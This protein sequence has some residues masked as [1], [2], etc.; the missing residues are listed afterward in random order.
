MS[1]L[2]RAVPLPTIPHPHVPSSISSAAIHGR[3]CE[4]L[5]MTVVIPACMPHFHTSQVWGMTRCS[6]VI[7]FLLLQTSLR[8]SLVKPLSTHDLYSQTIMVGISCLHS[9]LGVT[10]RL[11]SCLEYSIPLLRPHQQCLDQI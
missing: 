5:R 4:L 6:V 3:C 7:A 8:H 11:L 9:T 10:L 2:I 1:N